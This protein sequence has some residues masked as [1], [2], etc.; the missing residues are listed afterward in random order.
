MINRRHFIEKFSLGLA[1]L[2]VPT[3]LKQDLVN[4]AN[5][6]SKVGASDRIRVGL[7]GCAFMG[8]S[9]ISDFLLHPEVDCVALCD[10]NKDLLTSR[11]AEI[12]KLR[13]KKPTAF[14]D[15]RKML[16]MKDL[17]VAIVATPDHWHCLQ[18]VD[19]LAAGKDVY[20]EKPLA[21]SIAECD[22]MVKAAQKYKR[23]VSVGQQQRSGKHWNQLVGIVHSGVLGKIARI[24][25]WGN[26]TYGAGSLPVPDEPA[27]SYLDY[28]M[29]LG[30]APSR[31]HNP[32]RVAGTWR[33]FWDYG[34]GVMT[35]WGVHLLDIALWG[36]Q[37]TDFPR[38]VAALGGKYA[39][40]DHY[41][42]T[43]DTQTVIY[44]YGDKQIAWS[45]CG[46]P[47]T[48]FWN[49]NYGVAFQGTKGMLVAD[50]SS[51]ELIPDKNSGGDLQPMFV[52]AEGEAADHRLHVANYLDCIKTRNMLTGCTIDNGSFCAKHA[53]LGNI[54][55]RTEKILYFDDKN[56]TFGDPEAD[57]LIK[58]AYRSPWQFPEF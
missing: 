40:P 19:A 24:D 36:A 13:G 6:S 3:L 45:N 50:R 39:Y 31:N 5:E 58:P 7:I 29:W 1:A 42:E 16:E 4:A 20:V 12:E 52:N 33:L 10:V 26:F 38:K 30:P 27:P 56:K 57:K 28:E 8:W 35:D 22:A 53:H 37:I 15:Y 32:Q 48:G 54:A 55:A 41:P 49:R 44:D 9:N 21:N 2:S 25:V 11:I 34:G 46:G 14:T 23:I 43:F 17:D 18:T 51:F 47:E